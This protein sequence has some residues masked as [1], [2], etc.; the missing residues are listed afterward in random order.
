MLKLDSFLYSATAIS[1]VTQPR[2]LVYLYYNFSFIFSHTTKY[3]HNIHRRK[4]AGLECVSRPDILQ[5]LGHLCGRPVQLLGDVLLFD[6]LQVVV[7]FAQIAVDHVL[8][9]V[10]V[11]AVAEVIPAGQ[12]R[13]LSPHV[14][15]QMLEKVVVL[16]GG[17][18]NEHA[19][20]AGQRREH[21][22][23]VAAGDQV[24]FLKNTKKNIKI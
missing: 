16:P 22:T 1:V 15:L 7:L 19:D 20:G 12:G 4:N 2:I 23:V 11:G 17:E 8:D 3:F 9:G 5:L 24:G 6:D 10:K 13:R 14:E 21:K 18:G